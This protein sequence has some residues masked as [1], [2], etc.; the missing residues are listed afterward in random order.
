MPLEQSNCLALEP[1][2]RY[3][4]LYYGATHP[5]YDQDKGLKM[6]NTSWK[7]SL[8]YISISTLSFLLIFIF[9]TR[10]IIHR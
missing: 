7:K 3:Y 8:T 4:A 6:K 1:M 10:K 5:N 2:I 9:H